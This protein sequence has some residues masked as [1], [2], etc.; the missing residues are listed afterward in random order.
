MDKDQ[1][2]SKATTREDL[3]KATLAK[4]KSVTGADDNVCEATL[5]KHGYD[6]KR[7]IDAY[8]RQN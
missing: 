1:M 5:E 7:S 6:L 2:L 8:Y 4:M 3:Q